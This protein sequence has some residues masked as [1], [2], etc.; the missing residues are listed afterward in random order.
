MQGL[1][2]SLRALFLPIKVL[3]GAGW[4][5][6]AVWLAVLGEW[7]AI[8]VGVVGFFVSGW[9]LSAVIGPGLLL[10]GDPAGR[11]ARKG[12]RAGFV[13][14]GILTV[15]Y[16]VAYMTAWCMTVL[17]VFGQMAH[18]KSLFPMM[19]WSYAVATGPFAFFARQDKEAGAN[20]TSELA[21]LTSEVA[22]IVLVLIVLSGGASM[23]T[24][25]T[26]FALITAVGIVACTVMSVNLQMKWRDDDAA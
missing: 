24:L 1:S 3:N 9:L 26:T 23:L 12:N 25:L 11:C 8:G 10:F 19:I 6:S 13:L 14:F 20:P 4:I 15:L 2:T 17:Y 7:R 22:Y 18:G 16:E 5:V 21:A